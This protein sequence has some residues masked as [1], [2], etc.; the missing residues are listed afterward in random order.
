MKLLDMSITVFY[1]FVLDHLFAHND[2]FVVY[3]HFYYCVF[4]MRLTRLNNVEAGSGFLICT[5]GCLD[6]TA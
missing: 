6:C 2:K 3:L 5:Y 4:Y 1:Y